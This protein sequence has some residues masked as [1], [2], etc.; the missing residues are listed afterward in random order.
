MMDDEERH[1]EIDAVNLVQPVFGSN[2]KY[3]C[4]CS[5]FKFGE[6]RDLGMLR[7]H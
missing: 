4:L 6:V 3:A 1:N 5:V 2:I 7:Q